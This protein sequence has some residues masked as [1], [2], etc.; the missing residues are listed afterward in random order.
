MPGGLERAKI[1]V[2]EIPNSSAWRDLAVSF[3]DQHD[4]ETAVECFLKALELNASEEPFSINF[5][6]NI[7]RD[8]AR[9]H[10]KAGQN[11][12]ASREL[13]TARRIIEDL[14]ATIEDNADQWRNLGSKWAGIDHDEAIR[15]YERATTLDPGNDNAWSYLAWLYSGKNDLLNE[16]RCYEAAIEANWA[17]G[18]HQKEEI[19]AGLWHNLA[20]V[21]EAL[22]DVAGAEQ[23]RQK[24]TEMQEAFSRVQVEDKHNGILNIMANQHEIE[25]ERREEERKDLDFLRS[26]GEGVLDE[27]YI[28]LDEV[29]RDP[30]LPEEER[31]ALADLVAI[32]GVPMERFA[33]I[34]FNTCGFTAASEHV[35][36]LGLFFVGLASFPEPIL[37]LRSLKKLYL[38]NNKIETIPA[39]INQ[40]T[41]LEWLTMEKN[42]LVALPDTIGELPAI[43]LLSLGNN[44]LTTLPSSIV[45]LEN[46]TWL[47]LSG[48]P[49]I[50]MSDSIIQWL[51]RLRRLGCHVGI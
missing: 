3:E 35:T 10:E 32:V 4:Y 19:A 9:V 29:L 48:N 13:A 14:E 28:K 2:D 18:G 51:E 30:G 8:L 44:Q 5:E 49:L 36:G 12:E 1:I 24:E 37:R 31:E 34:E 39:G 40:L 23:C 21:N 46:L 20:K 6:I 16:K 38:M 11:D 22:G 25:A 50:A 41:S 26:E 15:C 27:E 47:N 45:N 42:H 17:G 33:T 7:H 43:K